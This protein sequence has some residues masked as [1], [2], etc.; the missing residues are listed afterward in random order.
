M[1]WKKKEYS[2]SAFLSHNTVDKPLVKRVASYLRRCGIK[3]WVDAYDLIPGEPWQEKLEEAIFSCNACVIFV[4]SNGLGAWQAEE[5]RMAISKRV[6]G[7]TQ[8]RIIPVLLPSIQRPSRSLLPPLLNQYTWIAFSRESGDDFAMAKIA[9]AVRGEKLGR[10]LNSCSTKR[11]PYPGLTRFGDEDADLFY[12]RD[13]MIDWMIHRLDRR[14]QPANTPNFLAL[15]GPSGSGKS[16]LALAGLIPVLR[17][18]ALGGSNWKFLVLRPGSS[19]ISAYR[20]MMAEADVGKEVSDPDND[21]QTS[22]KTVLL[23]DQFEEVFTLCESRN[24]QMAFLD[25]VCNL[26]TRREG[27]IVILTLRADFFGSCSCHYTLST[28]VSDFNVLVGPDDQ[29]RAT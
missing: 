12:G 18:G 27:V 29:G 8:F 5:M 26:A 13:G 23:V 15:I 16:S 11:C 21:L 10:V 6:E 9:S 2:L 17:K 3:P 19:P 14:L 4:G 1:I 7:D 28:L 22:L 25:L 24:E 20:Q